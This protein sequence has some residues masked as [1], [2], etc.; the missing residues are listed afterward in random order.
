VRYSRRACL[1]RLLSRPVE[2]SKDHGAELRDTAGAQRED[3][4]PLAGVR[5]HGL[6]SVTE[7]GGVAHAIAAGSE[8]ALDQELRVSMPSI[9]SSLAA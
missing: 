5:D 9:G 4:I 8:D 3:G 2:R 1:S 6:D 7:A